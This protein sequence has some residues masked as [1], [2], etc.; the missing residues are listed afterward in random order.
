MPDYA[1]AGLRRKREEI[2][3]EITD[4]EARVQVL[5]LQLAHI[6]SALRILQ[7]DIL[8]EAMPKRARRKRAKR[9]DVTRPILDAL[10]HA[11][12]PLT[13]R[14][15]GRAILVAQ[16]KPAVRV[17]AETYEAARL[18]LRTLKRKGA[19]RTVGK[20]GDSSLWELTEA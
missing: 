1:V 16:G 7:P 14:E 13:V 10:R 19:V 5:F 8:L 4:A 12:G 3:R 11:E 9:G 18:A 15:C 17:H 6:D 2:T 20:D